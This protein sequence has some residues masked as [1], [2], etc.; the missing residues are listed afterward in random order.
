MLTGNTW[1]NG[2]ID[3]LFVDSIHADVQV[4]SELFAWWNRV[5]V[6][7][8]VVFH[9]TNWSNYIHKPSHPCAGKKPGNSGKGYDSYGGRAWATPD[10]AVK[11]FFQIEDMNTENENIFSIFSPDDLGMTFIQKK[12]DYDF[13]KDIIDWESIFQDRDYLIRSF[14]A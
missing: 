12:S 3:I 2:E 4:I 14:G 6:G 11:K 8:W 5:K 9:D 7:G 10:V 1:Q 13:T